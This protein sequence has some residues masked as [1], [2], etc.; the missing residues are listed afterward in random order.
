MQ[1]NTSFQR[2][3]L[4]YFTKYIISLYFSP[5]DPVFLASFWF[6]KII[7]SEK[8]GKTLY[9]TKGEHTPT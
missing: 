8:I 2:N 1:I 6:L 4:Y 7:I 5:S 9:Y 3:L